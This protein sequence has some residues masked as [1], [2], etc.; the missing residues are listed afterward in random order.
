MNTEKTRTWFSNR[1]F[2]A[3][4]R[5]ALD[6][7]G[8]TDIGIDRQWIDKDAQGHP[9]I[10]NVPVG[11]AITLQL[12]PLNSLFDIKS[13]EEL[14]W[15][16]DEFAL[17]LANLKQAEKML[18]KYVRDVRTTTIAEIAAARADGLDILLEGVGLK[19]TYAHHLTGKDWKDAASRILA[20]VRIRTTSFFLQP[21]IRELHVEGPTEVADEIAV[22]RKEQ[23]KR[24][25]KLAELNSLGADLVVDTLTLDLLAAHGLDADEVLSKVWKTQCVNLTVHHQGRDAQLSIITSNGQV[26]ASLVLEEAIWNGEHLWLRDDGRSSGNEDLVGKSLGELVPH[27]VFASRPIA[28]VLNRQ[29]D[30]FSFDLSQKVLFDADTGRIWREERLAA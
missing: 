26:S 1:Q 28:A 14:K 8:Q 7:A 17:A 24:Q 15:H 29:V 6:E 10:V 19:P 20:S 2:I 27:P 16:S 22:I 3:M 5:S 25:A 13:V 9:L 23:R 21:E 12:L 11:P 18:E 30:Q 4:V